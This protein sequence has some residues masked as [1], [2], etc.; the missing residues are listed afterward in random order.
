MENVEHRT[1]NVKWEPH[2]AFTDAEGMASVRAVDAAE[3]RA[4][5]QTRDLSAHL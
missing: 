4:E 2:A 3:R 5:D 1:Q